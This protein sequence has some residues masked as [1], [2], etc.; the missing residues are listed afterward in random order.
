MGIF[1]IFILGAYKYFYC[2]KICKSQESSWS[3]ILNF[4]DFED[5][6]KDIVLP[7]SATL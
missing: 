3:I 2:Q 7:L 4:I 1:F 5:S 6:V